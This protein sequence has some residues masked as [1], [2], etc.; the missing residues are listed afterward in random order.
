MA[1]VECHKYLLSAV[2]LRSFVCLRH[3]LITMTNS[4][5]FFIRIYIN[6][7]KHPWLKLIPFAALY[8][9]YLT[10]HFIDVME[11]DA[12]QYAAI[13]WETLAR[14]NFLMFYQNGIDYLDKPPLLFWV[15]ALGYKIWGVNNFGY[16]FF[17]VLFSLLGVYS[18]YRLTK[19]YYK[20]QVAYTAALVLASCQAVF[21][22]NHDVRTD[23]MLTSFI[24]LSLWQ[25][26]AY[27]ATKKWSYLAG[28]FLAVG[29]A[30]LAK[31]P[32]GAMIPAFTWGAFWVFNREWKHIFDAKYLVGL[33]ITALVLLPMC[34]GLYMQFDMHPEKVVN[35]ETGVSGLRFYFWTQSFGRIT[36][37]NSWKNNVDPFFL[38]HTTLWSFL[39]WTI[40]LI[41]AYIKETL[42]GWHFALKNKKFPSDY[43]LWWG[44]TLS[45][46][47]LSQS[48]YQLNHYI[49]PVYPLAAILTAKW[50]WQM[51]E[52][53]IR[54][55]KTIHLWMLVQWFLLLTLNLVLAFWVFPG[56]NILVGFFTALLFTLALMCYWYLPTTIE[57]W[58]GVSLGS[59]LATN[60]LLN[61]YIYPTLLQ[62]Q[63]ESVIA[64]KFGIEP[65]AYKKEELYLLGE[66]LLRNSMDFYA[67]INLPRVS[68]LNA[69]PVN[70]AVWIAC[71]AATFEQIKESTRLKILAKEVYNDYHISQLS[72]QFLNP[73]TRAEV[74]KK[75]YLVRLIR[76]N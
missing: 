25:L 57:K 1:Y 31:G 45:F 55:V 37:E 10:G 34:I 71:D 56:L 69:L 19:L 33:G 50:M 61:G 23:N 30:M 27:N 46:T 29:F 51:A 24:A 2:N 66:G 41:I 49:Y 16:R 42:T 76:I 5:I 28:T 22:M 72:S 52:W 47:A 62:Y 59:I 21:L 75:T 36:G 68:E 4:G 7:Q 64:K 70:Q 17:P 26:A 74:V 48:K 40:F 11:V 18:T 65:H 12:A 38:V 8:T 15:S 60:I 35:N 6:H 67:Q 44:L 9:V 32:L 14:G 13:G 73:K 63:S 54:Q 58:V 39:P 43:F 53:P 20:E 3:N